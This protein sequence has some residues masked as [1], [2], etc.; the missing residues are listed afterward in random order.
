MGRAF[1]YWAGI[2]NPPADQNKTAQNPVGS[3]K[4]LAVTFNF[5]NVYT[6]PAKLVPTGCSPYAYPGTTVSK[7]AI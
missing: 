5:D 7:T 2:V 6:S 3:G 4:E 1:A